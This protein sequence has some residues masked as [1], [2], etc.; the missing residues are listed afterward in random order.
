MTPEQ[1]EA[2]K[3]ALSAEVAE[4]Q[5]SAK[6]AIE[7]LNKGLEEVRSKMEE[8]AKKN[9]ISLPGVDVDKFSMGNC[10]KAVRKGQKLLE[11][12]SYE[13]EVLRET[14]KAQTVDPT[15]AGGVFVPT[16]ISN[17]IV[18]LAIAKTVLSNLG[19]QRMTVQGNNRVDVPTITSA[20]SAAWFTELVDITDSSMAFGKKTIEPFKCASYVALS[21]E[22][23]SQPGSNVDKYVEDQMVKQ[24]ALAVD[25]AGLNGVGSGS[26]QPLGI[27]QTPSIIDGDQANTNGDPATWLTFDHLQELMEAENTLEGSLAYVSRPEILRNLRNQTIANFSGQTDGTPLVGVPFM[28]QAQLDGM[29][30]MPMRSTTQLAVGT[31]GANNTAPLI[32]GD[33]SQLLMATWGNLELASD[34]S[35]LFQ[36]YGTVMRAIMR[37]DIKVLREKSFVVAPDVI[38]K[39]T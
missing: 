29:V 2:L 21:N 23:L 37:T 10:M 9:E 17:R 34:T 8:Q 32:L 33:F 15:T 12:D 35:V 13:G 5:K 3:K 26:N 22:L 28:S 30:G 36:K 27:M 16:E 25:L 7:E 38:I 24:L 19:V 1:L 31:K 20:P 11:L 14:Q 4:G 39:A 18:E 6:E